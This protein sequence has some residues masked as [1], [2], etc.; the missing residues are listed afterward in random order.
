MFLL[1]NTAPNRYK[2]RKV[3][4]KTRKKPTAQDLQRVILAHG[5]R[6]QSLAFTYV[7]NSWDAEDIAQDVFI[8]YLT[9]SPDFESDKKERAW[10]MQVTVNRCRDL[11]RSRCRKELPLPEDLSYLPKQEYDLMVAMLALDEKYRV[12]L[13]LHYYEGYSLAEIGKMLRCTPGAIGS[14]LAR[15]REQLR[16]EL[17]EDYFEE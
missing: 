16:K 5:H 11:M 2:Y 6:I 7:K 12:P 8:A 3:V 15:G 10:L 1:K 13:H 17:G 4:I 9:K 14:R